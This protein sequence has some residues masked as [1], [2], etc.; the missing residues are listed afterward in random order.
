MKDLKFYSFENSFIIDYYYYI[1]AGCQGSAFICGVLFSYTD[2][3]KWIFWGS[4]MAMFCLPVDVL[5]FYKEPLGMIG[6][7]NFN[8]LRISIDKLCFM[9]KSD[10]RDII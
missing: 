10:N 8:Q 7:Y 2:Y 6:K 5:I 9:I 3:R 1:T 4:G